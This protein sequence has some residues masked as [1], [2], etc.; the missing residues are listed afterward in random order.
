M[1][2]NKT[3]I[4]III[5]GVLIAGSLIFLGL[6]LRNDSGSSN[7][8]SFAEQLEEYQRQQEQEQI[9]AQEEQL[10]L[11]TE[12]AKNVVPPSEDDHVLGDRDALI[13]LI[14]YSDF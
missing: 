10:R 5:A 2:E 6:Q 9:N 1:K 13:S 8:A 7:Q 14:E 4:A 12:Q 3:I 11:A